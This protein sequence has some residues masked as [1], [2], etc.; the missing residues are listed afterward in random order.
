MTVRVAPLARVI[1]VP[2]LAGRVQIS[3]PAMAD[4]GKAMRLKGK[5]LPK[6]GGHGDL[7]AD[8]KI[9]L[10]DRPDAELDALM[11]SWR[12]AGKSKKSS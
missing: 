1:A 4:T 9:T 3:V 12:K 10:P 2:T 11:K 5:G 8:L 7:L 6:K